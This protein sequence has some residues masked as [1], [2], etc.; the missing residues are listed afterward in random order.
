[1]DGQT[2]ILTDQGKSFDNNLIQELCDLAQ[3]KKLSTSP[4]YP[5]TNGH[6][7]CFNATPIS[8]LGMLPTHAKKNWQEWVATS[9]CLQLYCFTRN[10]V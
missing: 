5:E 6:C 4:Y 8:M 1:M 2:K 9:T 3:V 7:E 10:R